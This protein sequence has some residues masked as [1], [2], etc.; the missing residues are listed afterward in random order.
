[1]HYVEETILQIAAKRGSLGVPQE[2]YIKVLRDVSFAQLGRYITGLERVGL[3]KVDWRS[4]DRFV[5]F[6][7]ET[8]NGVA[9]SIYKLRH[10]SAKRGN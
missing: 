7:T 8:G 2:D 1:M 5:V 10:W 4:I 9:N 3:I 6:I